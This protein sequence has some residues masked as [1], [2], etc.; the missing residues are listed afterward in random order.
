MQFF[1]SRLK[2]SLLFESLCFQLSRH[3]VST[4]TDYTHTRFT[5]DDK[6]KWLASVGYFYFFQTVKKS[7]E[8][9]EFGA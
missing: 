8:Q 7:E 2:S 6:T 1:S 3:I 5:G 4:Y 9:N